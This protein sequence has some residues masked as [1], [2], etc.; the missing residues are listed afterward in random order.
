MNKTN[1]EDAQ[2]SHKWQY[3]SYCENQSVVNQAATMNVPGLDEE[4]GR[5]VTVFG[6]SQGESQQGQ[7]NTKESKQNT[8]ITTIREAS[9]HN[10]NQDEERSMEPGA[11]AKSVL[12]SWKMD[13]RHDKSNKNRGPEQEESIWSQGEN[14]TPGSVLAVTI[15]TSPIPPTETWSNAIW[16][17]ASRKVG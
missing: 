15:S 4:S 3:S 14:S 8:Q 2:T 1:N 6:E 9:K 7:A 13:D 11:S 5:S 12:K 10:S 17:R 16:S